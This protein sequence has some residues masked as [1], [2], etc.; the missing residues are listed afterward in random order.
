MRSKHWAAGRPA[1]Q[2]PPCNCDSQTQDGISASPYRLRQLCLAQQMDVGPELGRRFAE[3]DLA[4]HNRR[5]TS[6]DSCRQSDCASLCNVVTAFPPEVTDSVVIVGAGA[7]HAGSSPTPWPKE[8]MAMK[9]H[10]GRKTAS[11]SEQWKCK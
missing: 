8:T 4:R 1:R 2:E 3:V 6:H 5:A 9:H 7:A 10:K 11:S